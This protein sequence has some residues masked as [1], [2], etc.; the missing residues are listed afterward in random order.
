MLRALDERPG[1]LL[2]EQRYGALVAFIEGFV[3][4]SQ[5]DELNG[6]KD[7]VAAEL[8][9][10]ESSFHWST[11]VALAQNED[12]GQAGLSALSSEESDRASK[13][14]LELLLRFLRSAPAASQ[15][16]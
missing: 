2:P 13:A 15:R 12:V 8:L 5:S 6:F 3:V 9:N 7:W 10:R 14:L 11:I 4:G 1:M 16:R